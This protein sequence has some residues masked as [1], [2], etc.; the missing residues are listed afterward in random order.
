MK[1]LPQ[2]NDLRIFLIVVK[3]KSFIQTA[4]E[5]GFSRSYISK[6]IQILEENLNCKLLYRT[7]RAIELTG[8]G[9]KAYIWA[10]EILLNY[11]KMAEAIVENVGDPK[12]NLSITSSLGFDRQHIAPLLSMFVK[13]YPKIA[14]RFDT[15]DKIQDLVEQHVNLDIHIGEKITPNLIAKK[16]SE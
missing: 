1:A 12:G 16:I 3:N 9:E 7:S 8:Q 11:Q 14:I 15:I 5:L 2:I 6:R 10:Q 4:E 13:K